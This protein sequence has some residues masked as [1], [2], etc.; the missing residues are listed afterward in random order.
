M[1]VPY[2][3][4]FLLYLCARRVYYQLTRQSERI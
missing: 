1:N 2:N 4:Q 3:V